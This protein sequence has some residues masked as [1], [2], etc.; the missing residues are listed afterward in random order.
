MTTITL[1][2]IPACRIEME[3]YIAQRVSYWAM[4]LKRR[5]RLSR[6]DTDDCQQ[7]MYVELYTAMKWHDA[8]RSSQRTFISRVLR[9]LAR[10]IIRDT[11]RQRRMPMN[12]THPLSDGNELVTNDP[13]Q[14]VLTE[15]QR[16]DLRL[17]LEAFMHGLTPRL[18][19]VA[20]LLMEQ[21]PPQA[22][23]ELGWNRSS[24]CRAIEELRKKLVKA[25]F[26]PQDLCPR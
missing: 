6:E 18:R 20:C 22:A 13:S 17:D 7:E 1:P 14:G 15:T 16:V 2:D 3:R 12:Q 10:K 5:L 4:H 21:S 8:S 26:E 11:L 9:R 25:G 24:I 23:R 19:E